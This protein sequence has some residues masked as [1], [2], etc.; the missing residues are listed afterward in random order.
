MSVKCLPSS[1]CQN[2]D[3]C[4]VPRMDSSM[5]TRKWVLYCR[6][7]SVQTSCNETRFVS[8]ASNDIYSYVLNSV[9]SSV[10]VCVC[11]DNF[12]F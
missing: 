11:E 2:F 3:V 6:K 9:D 10:C 12:F 8:F 7:N 5:E 4:K 1:L